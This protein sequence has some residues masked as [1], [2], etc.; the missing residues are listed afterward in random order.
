[1]INKPLD[2]VYIAMPV[3][4]D[5]NT[6]NCFKVVTS[7]NK[8]CIHIQYELAK[9]YPNYYF[10]EHWCATKEECEKLCSILNKRC[11]EFLMIDYYKFRFNLS[12]QIVKANIRKLQ[13]FSYT[14]NIK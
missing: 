8:R 3:I 11:Y 2:I 7:N 4:K 10:I 1:M 5:F 13:K 12:G 9:K 6:I 14:C